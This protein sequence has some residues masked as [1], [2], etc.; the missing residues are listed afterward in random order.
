MVIIFDLDDT[1]YKEINF[2]KNGFKAVAKYIC[3]NSKYKTKKIYKEIFDI[4]KKEGRKKVFNKILKRKKDLSF[5]KLATLVEIYRHNRYNIKI[6][7]SD[8]NFI[9]KL[10]KTY[11]L[12]IVTDGSPEV[13]KTKVKK[14]S[15]KKYFKKIYYTYAFG[16]SFGKPSLKCFKLIKKKE[17]A[18]W[19]KIVYIA[20]NPRKDF[21]NL[22]KKKAMT[23]RILKGFNENLKFS[24]N[25]EAKYF[26]KKLSD[27]S[28]IINKNQ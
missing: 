16:K 20:D 22:N 19:R 23:I 2:I 5:Y 3:K 15:L 6:Q 11:P 27:I 21:V 13:Q 4:F 14:L 26:I 10:S 12:Y 8:L 24:K 28:N 9:K 25:Y 7:K 1:L 17:K 18:D